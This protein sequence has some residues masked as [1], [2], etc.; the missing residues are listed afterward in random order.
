MALQL[1]E[2]G[3]SSS[4][5][6]ESVSTADLCVVTVEN[7][8]GDEENVLMPRGADTTNLSVSD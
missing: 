7:K 6:G 2:E 3:V 5:S 1:D 4:S 8:S